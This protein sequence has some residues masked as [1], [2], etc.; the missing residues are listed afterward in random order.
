MATN[1]IKLI[2]EVAAGS[3]NQRVIP[4]DN[5]I[6]DA[7]S[8]RTALGI[9]DGAVASV[10]TQ[11]GVV[12]LDAADVG[13]P[14]LATANTL[15]DLNTF[16][17][18][19]NVPWTSKATGSSTSALNT[20]YYITAFTSN[21][22][23]TAYDSAPV[24]DSKVTYLLR[25]CNGT[26]TFTFPAAQRLGA[27]T[28]TSTSIAPTAGV[29]LII[30]TYVDGAWVYGVV[31]QPSGG[32]GG[33]PGGADGDLQV[34]SA[35]S[36]GGIAP[37]A[38][39]E[40]LTVSGGA[41]VSAAG[42]PGAVDS[43]NGQTG[44]VSLDAADVGAVDE[45]V[46]T[47]FTA[48]NTFNLIPNVPWTSKATGSSTS[49]L[50]TQYYITTFTSDTTISSY[51]GTPVDGS[52]VVYLL[53]GCNGTAV[54]NFPSAQR[55]GDPTGTS[56]TIVPT[57]GVHLVSFTYVDGAWIYQDDVVLTGLGMLGTLT[58][59][60]T[61]APLT[62]AS[63]ECYNTVLH[64][65]ATGQINLPARVSGM[66]L[67]IYNKGAFVITINP[68]DADIIVRDGTAQ[69]AGVSFTLSSGAGN[70]VSLWANEE[71]WVTGGFTGIL[72]AGS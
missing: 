3:A 5:A 34:N 1:D 52:K 70:F 30:F 11:T 40:V 72:A 42:S 49:T 43:V 39:G 50:N 17:L 55:S 6:T 68:A 13:A 23:I 63:Y 16:N 9:G 53:R 60:I 35:G 7:A 46:A 71:E 4:T 21:T 41:W 32:G 64:Y 47:T 15:T 28:G 54:F 25:G 66:N 69:S 29:N 56:T 61:T 67:I 8:F 33:T 37:G 62:L 48:L 24:N 18:A 2:Q 31:S 57:P 20:N 51:V 36:F 14:G 10:N 38:D 44:V 22:T 58:T 27:A 19:P 12:V 45:S 65:G 26:A 59:P